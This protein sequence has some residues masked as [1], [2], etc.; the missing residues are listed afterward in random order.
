MVGDWSHSTLG[1]EDRLLGCFKS[2]KHPKVTEI[3]VY[4]YFLVKH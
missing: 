2:G 4:I 3:T 1:R